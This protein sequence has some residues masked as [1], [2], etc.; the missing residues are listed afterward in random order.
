MICAAVGSS[1][2]AGTCVPVSASI[3][4]QADDEAN[5]YI[6]GI[7]I[8]PGGVPGTFTNQNNNPTTYSFNASDLSPT[9][10]NFFA[11]EDINTTS[12]Q[13]GADWVISIQCADGSLS[14]ITSADNAFWLYD[15]GN[16]SNP[17]PFDG[18]NNW[19]D[20]AWNNPNPGVYFNETPVAVSG[21]WWYTPLTNPYTGAPVPVLSSNANGQDISA[22]EI[23]YYRE[24][25]V[26]PEI[27]PTI[28]PTPYPTTCGTPVAF[29]TSALIAGGQPGNGV[30]NNS[31]SFGPTG[32]ASDALLL[33]WISQSSGAVTVSGVTYGGTSLLPFPTNNPNSW[34]SY[35]GSQ[36]LYYGTFGGLSGNQA[37]SVNYSSNSNNQ[38]VESA[39]LFTGVN[40][41][42]PFGNSQD[43]QNSNAANF[44]DTLT[45]ASPY[46]MVL[47]LLNN[48]QS[49]SGRFTL[50]GGQNPGSAYDSS[51]PHTYFDYETFPPPG[52]SKMS[53]SWGSSGQT[54][55]SWMLELQQATCSS[56]GTATISPTFS[57]SPTPTVSSTPTPTFS[58]TPT[59]SV[60]LTQTMVLSPTPT[61]SCTVTPTISPSFSVTPSLTISPT[62]TNSTTAAPSP[63]PYPLGQPFKLLGVY[64]NPV[65]ASGTTILFELP[66]IGTVTAT[67]YTLKGEKVFSQSQFFNTTYNSM[68]GTCTCMT[69]KAQNTYGAPVAFG[70]Y[71]LLLSYSGA[72]SS[73][74][75]GK[76]ISVLR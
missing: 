28:T 18:T 48:N 6:N 70:N 13:V 44:N 19:Y 51:G 75:T 69:W 60:S 72:S 34:T 22:S 4:V 8:G 53:Y 11:V 57:N 17:P 39:M 32:T 23:L 71:Y 12:P 35:S 63:T 3:T 43:N 7:Q 21:T 15:D 66:D 55:Y 45:T 58:N 74:Q 73:A 16:N 67:I 25:I 2:R 10:S 29:N 61:Y 54:A 42:S 41:T 27:T 14:Y 46:S 5:V 56:I 65:P 59:P 52:P 40:Q 76:W 50:G 64:P 33:V 30:T 9:G 37:L 36:Q 31:I 62:R 20:A 26:L 1:L 24:S 38:V 68:V 47:D 49:L